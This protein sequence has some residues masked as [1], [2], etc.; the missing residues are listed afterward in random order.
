MPTPIT[1]VVDPDGAGDYSSLSSWEAAQAR[2]LVALDENAI[3]DCASSTGVLPDT[4][5]CILSGWVTDATRNIEIKSDQLHNGIFNTSIY[6]MEPDYTNAITQQ[7]SGGADHLII[8]NIQF[9]LKPTFAFAVSCV[10]L[11]V[12]MVVLTGKYR[13]VIGCL[14]TETLGGTSP[15]GFGVRVRRDRKSVV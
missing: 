13:R 11:D 5:N 9:D 3:A 12:A 6:R 10:H 7:F 14:M 1:H 2:D 15:N 4:A 8:R